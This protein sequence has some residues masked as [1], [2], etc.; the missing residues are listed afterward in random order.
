MVNICKNNRSE[1]DLYDFTNFSDWDKFSGP[2][3]EKQ[4][5]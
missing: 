5:D 3:Y 4:S 2:Q 1:T